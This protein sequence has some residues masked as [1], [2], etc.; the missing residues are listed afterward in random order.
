[1]ATF[2]NQFLEC[3]S[4]RNYEPFWNPFFEAWG[5]KFPERAVV[6]KDIPLDV[7]LT[8]EQS[9]VLAEAWALRQQVLGRQ[10]NGQH[11][12]TVNKMM[13][14]IMKG[15]LDRPTC[16]LQP[17]EMYSKTH[18]MKVKDAVKTEQEELKKVPFAE[19]AKK[20]TLGIVKWHVK[21]AFGNESEEVKA[22]VLAAIEAMKEVKSAEIE[23]AKKQD[24]DKDVMCSYI[25]KIAVILTQ[26]FEELHEMTNWVFT[27]LMGG[28]HPAAGGTLDVSSFHVGTMKL[29]NRFSQA[30]PQFSQNIMVP[31]TQFVECVFRQSPLLSTRYQTNTS[32]NSRCSRSVEGTKLDIIHSGHRFWIFVYCAITL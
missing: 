6:F 12:A 29:G 21:A 20:T 15:S 22:E 32:F 14:N 5:A 2:H 30:Y 10:A 16:V 31:Y 28:P 24:H 1:M 18:Y 17:W 4:N 7:N 23:E 26:F 9:T 25:S 11:T 3:K 27:V 19:P 8:K 13:K